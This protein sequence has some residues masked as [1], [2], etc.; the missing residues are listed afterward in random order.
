MKLVVDQ[1]LSILD[2]FSEKGFKTANNAKKAIEILTKYKS[3]I[4]FVFCS[5]VGLKFGEF[6]VLSIINFCEENN[7]KFYMIS[8]YPNVEETF[9]DR[10]DVEYMSKFSAISY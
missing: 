7:I 5:Y 2:V 6:D 3:E 8:G 10:R 4:E 9:A 1:N